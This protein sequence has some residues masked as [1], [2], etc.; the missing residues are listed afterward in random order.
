MLRKNVDFYKNIPHFMPLNIFH[1]NLML[2]LMMIKGFQLHVNGIWQ[3]M[4][5]IKNLFWWRKIHFFY[6]IIWYKATLAIFSF[7]SLLSK[8]YT[9]ENKQYKHVIGSIFCAERKNQ[10]STFTINIEPSLIKFNQW[11]FLFACKQ[12]YIDAL[13][14]MHSDKNIKKKKDVFVL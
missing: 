9:H 2:L 4:K 12:I 14:K 11:T 8:T 5:H 13:F 6:T 3:V 10:C 1:L 7:F